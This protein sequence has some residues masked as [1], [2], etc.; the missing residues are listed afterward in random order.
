MGQKRGKQS[1]AQSQ[2]EAD[3]MGAWGSVPNETGRW[4]MPTESQALAELYLHQLS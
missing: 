2:G 3:R 1:W 4:E